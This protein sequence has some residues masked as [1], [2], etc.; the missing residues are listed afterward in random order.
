M[1][2]WTHPL[3]FAAVL[4]LAPLTPI[5]GQSQPAKPATDSDPGS[6]YLRDVLPIF[7]G[8]CARCHNE[9]SVLGNWLDYHTAFGDR[10][11][12][13]RRVWDSWRG[14]YYKQPMP[15]GNSPES[16]A[17]TEQE[18]EII[19]QW[20][21]AGAVRGIAPAQNV[22]NSKPERVEKGKHLFAVVCTP[23]HQAN[24]Q[25]IPG[26]FPP[27]AGS[28]FLNADKN[29]AIK[30]LI[31]GRQGQITVNGQQFN[32]SMPMF[33]LTDEDIASAL[34]F[35]YNSF[36]NSGKDVTAAEVKAMRAEPAEE[37]PLPKEVAHATTEASPFE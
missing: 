19:K 17:L 9:Q 8:K 15:A 13:R 12:I 20:V 28:D 37:T 16:E 2:S 31:H 29:R 1:N 36:G 6:T 21:D 18:R 26:K 4:F 14:H 11:E 30:V 35:V 24:G 7:M 23:C 10:R 32:N 27:L 3:R 5:F 34:T 33:P 25:G 22:P